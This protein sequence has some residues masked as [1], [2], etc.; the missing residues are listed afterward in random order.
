MWKWLN[1]MLDEM[2]VSS[3]VG[4][5]PAGIELPVLRREVEVMANTIEK[6]GFSVVLSH[7]D[8]KPSNVMLL[9]DDPVDD[10]V[11]LIDL[12]VRLIDLELAGPNYR[13]FDLAKLFRIDPSRFSEERFSEFLSVYCETAKVD[14]SLAKE[15]EKEMK[16]CLPLVHLEAAVF[17]ALVVAMGQDF[18]GPSS[19]KARWEALLRDRWAKYMASKA[20]ID[21][22]RDVM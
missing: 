8:L 21:V 11:R 6:L 3:N 7:G 13:G 15:I 19:D 1:R 4:S 12:D 20:T 5:L 22:F 14:E 10:D 2:R 16:V 18:G 17:F 9:G